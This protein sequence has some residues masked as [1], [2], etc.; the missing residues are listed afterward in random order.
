PPRRHARWTPRTTA[1]PSFTRTASPRSSPRRR[2]SSTAPSSQHGPPPTR[3]EARRDPTWQSS[4]SPPPTQAAPMPDLPH[5]YT[6]REVADALHLNVQTVQAYVRA[7]KF[8]NTRTVGRKHLIPV[9]DVHAF[10]YPPAPTLAPRNT[11]SKAQQ[12]KR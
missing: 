4:G 8:P 7:G 12:R 10:L 5:L 11:R 2:C 3:T 9:D 1:R 6:T